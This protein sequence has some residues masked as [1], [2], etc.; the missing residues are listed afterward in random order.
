[1]KTIISTVEVS[2]T[3]QKSEFISYLIPV[4]NE[5]EAKEELQNIKKQHPKAT[6][7]C[8]AMVIDGITRSNDDG[9]PASTAGLPMLQTLLGNEMDYVLAVVVRYY[10][11]TL[12][13]KGGLIRAYGSS[14]TLAIA[15]AELYTEKKLIKC[16]ATVSFDLINI[17]ETF[18]IKKA[19]ILDRLYTDKA[20]Y[21]LLIE[22]ESLMDELKELTLNQIDYSN[23]EVKTTLVKL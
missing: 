6:H 21:I 22:D 19:T 16:H 15:E 12:L 9:E 8:S 13:G 18:A 1:M 5:D 2:Q 20:T 3:I 10:G 11:G 23:I 7:H 17:I 4:K 14:V